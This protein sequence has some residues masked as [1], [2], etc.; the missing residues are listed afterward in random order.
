[1]TVA[2]L[3]NIANSVTPLQGQAGIR[4]LKWRL[5]EHAG[6]LLPKPDGAEAE[7]WHADGFPVE[8]LGRVAGCGRRLVGGQVAILHGGEGTQARLH[9]VETCGSVWL[10]PVCASK[11][12]E[13]KRGDIEAVV[14]AHVEGRKLVRPEGPPP[15]DSYG[16]WWWAQQ[17][18]WTPTTP[19][20]VYMV[21]LTVPHHAW[22]SLS[23]LREN[24]ADGWRRLIRG[25]PWERFKDRYGV[26]G[27]IRAMEVTHGKNGWHPHLHV[28]LLGD[29]VVDVDAMRDWLAERWA[30][31]I[32]RLGLADE[33]KAWDVYE[34][35]VE[36]HKCERAETA[37]DYLGKWG[38]D[39]E[40]AKWHTKQGRGKN[41]SPWDLLA[42][43][44][45]GDREAQ[46]LWRAFAHAFAGTKHMTWSHGLRERFLSAPELTDQ[47]ITAMEHDIPAEEVIALTGETIVGKLRRGVW[48]RVVRAG[49]AVDLLEQVEAGGWQ[50]ALDLLADKGLALRRGATWKS[51][52]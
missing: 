8:T 38:C 9:G 7:R 21:T 25:A 37:G 49:L 6:R 20:G 15:A 28:L 17:R 47:Q 4:R 2:P 46:I 18:E 52:C 36:A 30:R 43:A 27:F 14:T 24:V 39:A 10:C 31:I 48:V 34:H 45:D 50:A 3:G 51:C 26:I 33:N 40:L 32:A 23:H 13:H 12:A 35:G 1:M 42:D 19:G 29:A 11:I 41:R 44:A 16:E 22:N 5:R